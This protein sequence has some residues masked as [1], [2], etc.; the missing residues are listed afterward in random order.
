MFLYIFRFLYKMEKYRLESLFEFLCKK[1]GGYCIL[2]PILFITRTEPNVEVLW[3][4]PLP[5]LLLATS[6]L[7]SGELR[8]DDNCGAPEVGGEMLAISF[9]AFSLWDAISERKVGS[10]VVEWWQN[11]SELEQLHCSPASPWSSLLSLTWRRYHP[12]LPS[13]APVCWCAGHQ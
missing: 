8:P 10:Y 7:S 11:H 4:S 12:Y 3:L 5:T 13:L 9:V 2:L 6:S 1:C